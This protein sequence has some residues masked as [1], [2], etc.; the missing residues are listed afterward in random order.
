MSGGAGGGQQ[1]QQLSGGGWNAQGKGIT[2]PI[3]AAAA[4]AGRGGGATRFG[5]QSG[6]RGFGGAQQQVR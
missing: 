6:A 3:Y 5:A 4:A 1:Q 2:A